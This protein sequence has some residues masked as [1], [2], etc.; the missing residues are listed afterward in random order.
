MAWKKPGRYCPRVRGD[1]GHGDFWK[2]R[3][4]QGV[5][6]ICGDERERGHECIKSQAQF[7]ISNRWIRLGAA[8]NGKDSIRAEA[9]CYKIPP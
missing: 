2:G 5:W 3:G 9:F 4:D 7:L 6:L 1:S 8:T